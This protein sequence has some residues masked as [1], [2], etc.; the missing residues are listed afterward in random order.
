MKGNVNV[1]VNE[2]LVTALVASMN[3]CLK[4]NFSPDCKFC[5]ADNSWYRDLQDLLTYINAFPC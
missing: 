1:D 4:E 2:M 3:F 5:N